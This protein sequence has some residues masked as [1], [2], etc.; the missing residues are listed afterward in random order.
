MIP[1]GE[2]YVC[3]GKRYD[4]GAETYVFYYAD[5]DMNDGDFQ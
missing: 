2:E 4:D 1:A 3:V 5:K